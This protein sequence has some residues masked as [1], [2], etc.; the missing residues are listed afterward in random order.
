MFDGSFMEKIWGSN[1]TGKELIGL[2][3]EMYSRGS[4]VAFS[5]SPLSVQVGYSEQELG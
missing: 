3:L 5:R 1:L 2:A 4:G